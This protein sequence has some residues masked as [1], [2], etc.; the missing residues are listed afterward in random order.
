MPRL[1]VIVV[2]L[3]FIVLPMIWID[4]QRAVADSREMIG[5][6]RD[7][8]GPVVGATVRIKGTAAATTTDELGRFRLPRSAEVTRI[9]ATKDGYFIGGS[10]ASRSPLIIYLRPLSAEDN[11][12]YAWVDPTPNPEAAI[13]CG[14][15]HKAM[16]EEW[17]LSAHAR[18]SSNRR[19]HNL[20]EGTD[21]KGKPNVGWNLVKEHP[22]GADICSSCHAPTQKAV[23]F[24]SFDLRDAGKDGPGLSGVHCD[25]CHKILGPGD[26]EF[27][28]THGRFQLSLNRPSGSHQQFFG[29]LDDVDRGDDVFN[30]FQRDSRL[31]AACHEGVVFGV[32]VYTTYSE[33]QKSPA[34]LA[35][36]SCQSCHM[37]PT[38]K[39]SNIAPG[40]GGFRRDPATL[41]NH[42][43]FAGSQIDMLRRCLDLQANLQTT[44]E[45]IS[46]T[47]R[48]QAEGVGH[49]VPTGY[50]DRQ[51]LLVV[52]GTA[53]D[54][55]V[56]LLS[57]PTLPDFLGKDEAGKPGKL[58]AKSL[59]DEKGVRPAPFWRADP[60]TLIDTRLQPD[61]TDESRYLFPVNTDRIRIRLIHRRFWKTVAE[62]KSW[63]TDEQ[64][65][66]DREIRLP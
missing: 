43:F 6:V 14:N 3:A 54:K 42:I 49:R 44:N 32:P 15:C 38:G 56:S 52:E 7:E 10:A 23:P 62:E 40:H 60:S 58:F 13:N 5:E 35:G 51:L 26:G 66:I 48:L 41:N 34:G 18:S 9:T 46:V 2:A 29:P 55:Q 59:Q 36:K 64:T 63:P 50:V 12:D 31:C 65:V 17:S 25:F 30:R 11:R 33:W 53:G 37:A 24:G 8:L 27:G 20:Y 22:D 19:L 28:L 16:H 45:G 47:I 39:M 57:G 1:L 21:W 61:S 4:R